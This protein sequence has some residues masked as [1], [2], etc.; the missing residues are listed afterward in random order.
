MDPAQVNRLPCPGTEATGDLGDSSTSGDVRIADGTSVRPRSQA[1]GDQR[2]ATTLTTRS[3]YG[4]RLG[5]AGPGPGWHVSS[6]SLAGPPVMEVEG[7]R[8]AGPALVCGAAQYG[9]GHS[10]NERHRDPD[11]GLRPSRH[12]E[13]MADA[14]DWGLVPRPG[15]RTRRRS[16]LRA[17]NGAQRCA[18]LRLRRVGDASS[19]PLPTQP[20]LRR[21]TDDAVGSATRSCC[22]SSSQSSWHC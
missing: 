18:K 15:R 7:R 8:R 14:I 6:A 19:S 20:E 16:R 21:T 5:R 17:S 1:R 13:A 4:R 12:A 2:R 22:S 11:A 9:R 3:S 10:I